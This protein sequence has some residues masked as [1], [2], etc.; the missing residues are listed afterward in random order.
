ME[1]DRPIKSTGKYNMDFIDWTNEYEAVMDHMSELT[2]NNLSYD[3][4]PYFDVPLSEFEF[5]L[6]DIYDCTTT[7][8]SDEEIKHLPRLR[9][10]Q[11]ECSICLSVGLE[12]IKLPCGHVFHSECIT[13]WLKCKIECP[14][15]RQSARGR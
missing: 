4:N 5:M 11:R 10:T 8:L 14:N 6:R 2:R 13:R 12:G 15:C 9:G 1:R 3:D 7:G